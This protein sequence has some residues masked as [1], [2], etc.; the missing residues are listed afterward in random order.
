MMA[1]CTNSLQRKTAHGST[2]QLCCTRV[3]RLRATSVGEGQYMT[4]YAHEATHRYARRQMAAV[5]SAWQGDDESRQ[6]H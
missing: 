1:A 5:G 6:I 2:M 3:R 4:A